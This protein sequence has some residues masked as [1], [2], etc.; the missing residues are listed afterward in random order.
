MYNFFIHKTLENNSA[1][2]FS[3]HLRIKYHYI[4]AKSTFFLYYSQNEHV[5]FCK[6][7]KKNLE[8]FM[9]CSFGY[10]LYSVK[11]HACVR[12]GA[13]LLCVWVG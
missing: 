1:L 13:C 12:A 7:K 6:N 5:F 4:S 9:F 10:T 8:I 3:K 2:L 11:V